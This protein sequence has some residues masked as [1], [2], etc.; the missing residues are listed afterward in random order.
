MRLSDSLEEAFGWLRVGDVGVE[1]VA[2]G[3]CVEVAVAVAIMQGYFMVSSFIMAT[4]H[5][6]NTGLLHLW[7]TEERETRIHK[8][9]DT[10]RTLKMPFLVLLLAN[11]SVLLLYYYLSV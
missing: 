4:C 7:H 8:I 9:E 1:G 3:R 5:T 6:L 10:R 11:T 2:V